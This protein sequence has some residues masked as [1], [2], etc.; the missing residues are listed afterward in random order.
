MKKATRF[1]LVAATLISL[2]TAPSLSRAAGTDSGF[3][4]GVSVMKLDDSTDGPNIGNVDSSTT[5]LLGKIGYTLSNG[6]Y[7]GGV[8][9]SRNDEANGSKNERSSLGATIG[10]HNSGWF[11]DGSY[12]FSSTLKLASGTELKEG[13]GFGVDLGK[14]F[15]VTSNLYLG[16]QVSYKSFTYTKAGGADA[17][18][19]IKSELSPMLNLG[20]NF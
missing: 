5:L 7:V 14:N 18:N 4:V 19:K 20:V 9:D 8:Y 12:Y 1:A 17:T 6:L 13:S 3:M 2:S 11:I 10:Y 16:L 15:D